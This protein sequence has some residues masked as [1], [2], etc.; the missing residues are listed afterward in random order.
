[1]RLFQDVDGTPPAP[2]NC[3]GELGVDYNTF[4]QRWVMLYNCSNRTTANM[5]G[6]YM[7]FAQ[8]PW[9]SE[10]EL[11]AEYARDVLKLNEAQTR[12]FRELCLLATSA[13]YRGQQS[14]LFYVRPFWLRETQ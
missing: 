14:E 3:T 8:Q 11:F 9:R 4:L 1:M 13:T 5:R 7:R 6:I 10:P 2:K 12:T